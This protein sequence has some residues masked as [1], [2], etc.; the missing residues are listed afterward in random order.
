MAELSVKE[1]NQLVARIVAGD[2]PKVPEGKSEQIYLDPALRRCGFGIRVLRT[3]GA[4]WY[5][6]YKRRG[7]QRKVTLGKVLTMDRAT[8]IDLARSTLGRMDFQKWDPQADRLQAKKTFESL[9]EPFLAHKLEQKEDK[10]VT[11]DGYRLFLENEKYFK[12]FHKQPLS[13]ITRADIEKRLDHIAANTRKHRGIETP[14]RKTKNRAYSLLKDF[15]NWAI[16][17]ENLPPGYKNPMDSIDAPKPGEHRTRVLSNDE[18]RRIWKT[19]EGW[20]ADVLADAEFGRRRKGPASDEGRPRAVMLLFLTGCR[21]IEIGQLQWD[22][23]AQIEA[24]ELF[25]PGSKTKN[26]ENLELPLCDMAIDILKRIERRPGNPYVFGKGRKGLKLAGTNNK[27]DVH[28]SRGTGWHRAVNH[29]L[30]NPTKERLVRDMLNAGASGKRIQD[31]A[32]VNRATIAKIKA[33]MAEGI[34]IVP[35]IE[36]LP[37][38]TLHDIRRTFVTRMA[39]LGVPDHIAERLVNH[40]QGGK[41]SKIRRTYNHH[42]YWAQKVDAINKWQKLLRDIIDGTAPEVQRSKSGRKLEIAA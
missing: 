22:S 3:G 1:M 26:G 41:G 8:A 12:P 7:I 24:K 16:R 29:T 36:P 15:I 30:I 37:I 27:I 34:E 13:L 19:C 32:H 9:I 42:E 2:T 6:H 4:S 17:S 28:M 23:E 10:Q 5:M 38:W 21:T 20:E 40:T 18:I 33:R 35:Q 31:E 11:V 25:L 39:E 14:G